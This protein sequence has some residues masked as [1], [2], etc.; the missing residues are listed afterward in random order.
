MNGRHGNLMLNR[1]PISLVIAATCLLQTSGS[2]ATESRVT[3]YR[4]DYGQTVSSVTDGNQQ[5]LCD[6]CPAL[7][8][9]V[10]YVEPKKIAMAVA[11]PKAE[12]KPWV[13][14]KTVVEPPPVAKDQSAVAQD[15]LPRM[16]VTH[17][18]LDSSR[19]PATE[20]SAIKRFVQS[21]PAGV[22]VSV[23]VDGHTCTT[24]PARHN[25]VLS[26]RRAAAVAAVLAKQ[27]VTVDKETGYGARF[28][29][30]RRK[31]ADR[32]AEIIIK[33]SDANGKR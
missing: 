14:Q 30:G 25:L 26:R 23:K 18:K 29:T 20:A 13:S 33:E 15:R 28:A 32:R 7:L 2:W 6:N 10:P 21:L 27:G 3:K 31:P 8:R 4:Y 24:G 22:A 11:A 12:L 17:F 16:H 9:L 1:I 19:I 5:V